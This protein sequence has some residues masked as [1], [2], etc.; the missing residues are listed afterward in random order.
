MTKTV[1][2]EPA[3]WVVSGNVVSDILSSAHDTVVDLV[4][5]AY[6]LHAA[7]ATVNPDSYFLRF[8]EKPDARIIA[9]PA[10]LGGEFDIAGIKWIASFPV[11][12]LRGIPRASAVLILNDYETGFPIACLESSII[13][14]T[15]TAASAVLAAE[16]LTQ[17][18]RRSR[19]LGLVGTGFI[20]RHILEFFLAR[21]WQIEEVLLFDTDPHAAA[22]FSQW[23][24]ARFEVPVRVTDDI[25]GT[26]RRADVVVFATTA[27]RPYVHEAKLFNHAP[28]VI[29][30]SLRD[31]DVPLVLK[32]QNIVDDIDHCLKANTSLHLAEQ[33]TGGRDFVEGSLM[34]VLEGRI[35][36]D[37]G[38]ARIFSPFGLGI[39]DLALGS[40][41]LQQAIDA[42]RA[43]HVA[44]FFMNSEN[45]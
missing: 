31:I 23:L 39:L 3:L 17:P 24:A 9:L 44:N 26:T 28:T 5:K 41:V 45:L 37:F 16:A 32:A 34:D 36:P 10:Y 25:D 40:Y 22:T 7:S 19:A 13:S 8:P 21:N 38:R 18:D 2:G 12:R 33:A 4:R 42:G 35:S 29:H 30:V 27:L 1:K 14:A 15:R 20:A 43:I 6:A 11:N